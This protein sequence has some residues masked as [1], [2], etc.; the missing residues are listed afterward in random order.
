M[1]VPERVLGAEEYCA[2]VESLGGGSHRE[3]RFVRA[4]VRGSGVRSRHSALA[5]DAQ[6]LD[7]YTA[8]RAA[9][10]PP[11][12]A[13]RMEVYACEAPA[14]AEA[15]AR[16]L[17]A[18]EGLDFGT[19]THLVTVSCTGFMAPGLDYA[20]VSRL[21]L[22]RGTKRL[23]L[24]FMGC[25]G[26]LNGM[27]AAR[28]ICAGDT[29]A[30]VLVVMV[31]LCTLHYQQGAGRDELLPNALFADGA[32]AFCLRTASGG[33]WH[34]ESTATH[35]VPDTAS[36]MTWNIT[37]TGFRMTLDP[38]VPSV[39][40]RSL[41][42]LAAEWGWHDPVNDAWAIHPGG[43]R[44]LD[45]AVEALGLAAAQVEASRSVLRGFG[46][47]SSATTMFVVR[48]LLDAPQEKMRLLA[49]GPGLTVEAAT[50]AR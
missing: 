36:L 44:I 14:L 41:P 47:M 11:G 24:G 20:L 31:E 1:A 46:N 8:P 16:D 13:A 48:E 22:G 21:E 7:F 50:L 10:C 25:H 4:A 33:G 27:A 17:A 43:P 26:A 9:G 23:H 32:A 18:R 19:V 3:G 42:P 5:K 12:T 38:S 49:F 35:L 29:S 39:V 34:V 28:A 6:G 37:D 15:A 30:V 45:A 2:M 40:A